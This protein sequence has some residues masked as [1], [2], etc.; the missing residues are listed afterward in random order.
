MAGL[1]EGGNEPPGSLKANFTKATIR[2]FREE[3]RGREYES[4]KTLSGRGK[5]VEMYSEVTTANSWIA[6][7]KGLSTSE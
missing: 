1:C 3:L 7:K 5:G 6:N 2:N 4:W